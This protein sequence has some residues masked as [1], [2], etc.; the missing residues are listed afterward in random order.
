MPTDLPADISLCLYRIIQE[1]L[2]NVVRHSQAS[3]ARVELVTDTD[4]LKLTITD[5]GQGFDINEAKR[6]DGLGLVSMEERMRL[7]QGR[8]EVD[9]SPGQGT[10]VEATVPLVP[11]SVP[12]R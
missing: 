7:L 6:T 8:I 1:S 10:R 2:G 12:V 9:S 11:A 3:A 5:N 4:G